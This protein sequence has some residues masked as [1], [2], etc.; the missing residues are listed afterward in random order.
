MGEEIAIDV[1]ELRA[2][3]QA[4]DARGSQVSFVKFFCGAEGDDERPEG[5]AGVFDIQ[6]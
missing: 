3:D 6:K 2:I 4:R 5:E 1:K